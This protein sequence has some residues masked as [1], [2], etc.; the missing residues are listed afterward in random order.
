[1]FIHPDFDCGDELLRLLAPRSVAVVETSP[2]KGT[3]ERPYRVTD[4][5]PFATVGHR[6]QSHIIAESIARR[7]G[8]QAQ[9]IP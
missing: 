7:R 8:I 1:M 9:T 6:T 5:L 3:F 2:R 4:L